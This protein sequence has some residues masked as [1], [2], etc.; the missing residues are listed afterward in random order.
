MAPVAGLIVYLGAVV[1]NLAA[2]T[3]E[4]SEQGLTDWVVTLAIAAAGV[5]VAIWAAR[6]AITRGANSMARTSLIL[7]VVAVLSMVVF[8][9]GLPCVFGATALALGWAARPTG[10]DRA[11]PGS[12]A[13]CSARWH[14]SPGP[15]RWW[16]VEMRRA[17]APALAT[18]LLLAPVA[19]GQARPRL[20]RSC[21][22]CTS[23]RSREPSRSASART[24]ASPT[25]ELFS[26]V[27]SGS[28]ALMAPGTGPAARSSR[29]AGLSTAPS[30]SRHRTPRTDPATRAPTRSGL[31]AGSPTPTLTRSESCTSVCTVASPGVT[32]R[33]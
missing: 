11:R 19:M 22:G 24:S 33:P 14:W 20:P 26:E 2:D 16:W 31:W 25:R 1:L 18:C 12:R 27:R 30:R 9:A 13:C 10:D 5:G 4:P 32:A 21:A 17:L 8:W 28:Y 29:S 7:G 6:R 3:G 15:S 23:R